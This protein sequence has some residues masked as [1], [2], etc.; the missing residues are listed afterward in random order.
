[1]DAARRTRWRGMLASFGLGMAATLAAGPIAWAQSTATAAAPGSV[2]ATNRNNQTASAG[3]YTAYPTLN[4][5][6]VAPLVMLVM[7]RDEQ[8][9]IKAY[10]DYT[11]L[12]GDG[13]IDSTYNNNFSYS[14]YFDPDLC[15]AYGSSTFKA[16]G[17]ASKH[18]CVSAQ[19]GKWSG[20]FLNWVAMSRLDVVRYVLYGGYRSTDDSSTVLERAGIPND[21]HAWAKVYTGSDVD[22]YTPFSQ[23]SSNNGISF[24]NAT[25]S[26][27]GVPQMRV[28]R[29][30]WSEWASTAARQCDWKETIGSANED[31]SY[32]DDASKS[33]DGLG[34]KEYTVRVQVC[35]AG[36]SVREA[37]CQRYGTSYKPVGLLQRY[38]EN[39]QMRFGLLTGSFSAPRSG[40]VLRRNIGKLAGNGTADAN[41]NFAGCATGDEVDLS[42]GQFCGQ[43]SG[44][45][46]IINTLNRI[47]L[48]QWNYT[49]KWS[50]CDDYGILNR[51]TSSSA[52]SGQKRLKNPGSSGSGSQNCSAWGNPLSEMYAEALR[53][54]A[55]DGAKT[56]DFNISGDLSGLPSVDW[57]DPY[58]V[59]S[60][61]GSVRNPYCAG[62]SI[63]VLSTGLN[64]F[65][66]DEIPA[67]SALG[68]DAAS[69]ATKEVGVAEGIS[70]NYLVGRVGLTPKNTAINTYE[71]LC[72]ANAVTDLS[73]VR[74]ICPDIPSMEGSYLIAGLAYR[75][76]TNDLRPNLK[77]PGG[78]DRPKVCDAN[79][80]NCVSYKN[81]VQTYAVALAENL[82]KFQIP[83]GTGS[84]TLAPLCQANNSGSA[85]ASSSGWRSCYLG[86]VGIGQK[87]SAI[88]PNNYIYGRAM[89]SNAS[90]G[91]FSLVWEDSLWGNDHDNDVVA[92]LTYCVGSR[93]SDNQQTGRKKTNGSA[94][95]GY[96]ICWRS[97]S[98][99]CGSDGKPSVGT[100]EV[101]VRI[102]VLSA[103]AG[104]AMLSGYTV[105]GSNDDGVKRVV[106]R[107][108][109]KNGSV[110]TKSVDP[111]A[112]WNLPKVAKYSLGSGGARQLENPLYYA[113]KYGGFSDVA[114][115][116]GTIATAP[117]D[118]PK[119]AVSNWDRVDNNTGQ[120]RA[121]GGGD[122][123]PDNFFPV[124][125]PALLG[126]RLADVFNKILARSGSGTS[127][128][129]V[130]T[131]AGGDGLTYQ[132]LYQA[133]QQN[134]SGSQKV[135]WTGSL[136]AMWTDPAG[137]MRAG[138]YNVNGVPTLGTEK[139]SPIVLFC[140]NA[141]GESRFMTY[142]DASTVPGS[143]PA[144]QCTGSTLDQ[145]QPVW[146]AQSLL[147]AGGYQTQ[148]Q[149]SYNA[150][151]TASSGR[152][153]FTWV[154]ENH[155]GQVDDG[156]QKD[157]AWASGALSGTGTCTGSAF[158]GN[159]R[160]LNT[161]SADGAASLVSWVRGTELVDASGK[162]DAN[163]R[164]RTLDGSVYRL[165]DIINSTPLAV[166]TPAEAFDLLYADGSYSG[167]R[168][169]YQNRR[170]MVYVGANDGM[171]H[172]F[173]GG[174][175]DA[176]AHQLNTQPKTCSKD[177]GCKA[178]TG[179]T[180]HPLGAEVWAYVPG[181]LL[182][183]LRWLA[184]PTY[185]HMFYVDGSAISQDVRIFKADKDCAA[186]GRTQCHPD[187]W[188][189]V[190]IVPFRFGGGPIGLDT[191][192]SSNGVTVQNSFPA[193]VVLD[194]TNPEAPPSVLAELTNL[195]EVGAGCSGKLVSCSDLTRVISTYTSS[196]PA[197][198]MFRP[199]ATSNPDPSKFYLFTGSGTTD[200]GGVGTVEGGT[201]SSSAG[202]AIRGFDM[203]NLASRDATPVTWGNGT[204][205][206]SL[207]NTGGTGNGGQSFAG[208]LIASDFNLDGIAESLY[209]GSVKGSS[210]TFSGGLWA[211]DFG[212]STDPSAWLP[213]QVLSGLG[214]PVTIRPTLGL[215]DRQ[216]RMV[217][218]GTGRAYTKADMSSQQQQVI[219]AVIDGG[220]TAAF[221]GLQDVTNIDITVD[222]K[223][224]NAGTDVTD[225]SA[226]QALAAKA[227]GW[228]YNL[229]TTDASGKAIPSERVV[230][231]QA[232]SDRVLLTSTYLPGT[233]TCTDQGEGFL[234]GMDYKS[235][236]PNPGLAGFL[237]SHS[238]TK[239][240][241]INRSV[242]L[243]AGLPSQPSL[244]RSVSNG[245]SQ[246]RVCV[247]TSTGAI[248]CYDVPTMNGVNSGEISWREP[249]D[250]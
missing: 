102:E 179:F 83:V 77:T 22:K 94:Y 151:A 45:E 180:A 4:A 154:D 173:N 168:R 193:Y 232:L 23:S 145:L 13:L 21:L 49:S 186:G 172:A 221:S 223:V 108:G 227:G 214:K 84:I 103:Y 70:G 29:G 200:N 111:D 245:S 150:A 69:K 248:I 28:A 66:S 105:T 249:L 211:I 217:F 183:H 43:A 27:G 53:Y 125:N 137:H 148:T 163:W 141:Q 165:G 224:L 95:T 73:L 46:G 99:I 93:C 80:A 86:A 237:G 166:G 242:S 220:G 3:N 216:Q 117:C 88:S 207:T 74:G 133:Q 16:S 229:S 194:V 52:G 184:D 50:D 39:G 90:A 146:S 243:G 238:T 156:E 210:T 81:K 206:E 119:C 236:S 114:Q 14:G 135:S 191:K 212:G 187:G 79:G 234:Y 118:P 131:S 143:I 170:Q 19:A 51:E 178:D 63:I 136:N 25:V 106:L 196:L 41:G 199:R 57:K 17:A 32:R 34:D 138:G 31:N 54:V 8:L 62:C 20:N 155:N 82:P 128:A 152:Y 92:M 24:C 182:P 167:F 203:A 169:V 160:F 162:A 134:K 158:T 201:A 30:N 98:T 132:A 59:D 192:L 127:A 107:P 218:F 240:M 228:Y 176:S 189:T 15:Y 239:G 164:S 58:G 1:M 47:A 72:T 110:L 122:G 42:T 78:L 64:S 36:S 71:D 149:R 35:D 198:A 153:I 100:N 161:C 195:T 159:F 109:D 87:T 9:F 230:S 204:T 247:Q 181:N 101:L 10:T 124:R 144:A 219:A 202:L 231:T 174:F 116:D 89:E 185:A 225:T 190:L 2:I 67:I 208:D 233:D 226:L 241:I 157:F 33:N 55:N 75:A 104:N 209:F 38:G 65:D 244:K 129:V 246:L 142:T 40:G 213:R 37:F 121:V 205:V 130:S 85:T 250:N 91:S 177:G 48:T 175:Y 147:S 171:L 68:T 215:N 115:S 44:T 26:S 126:E 188:G 18:Q 139:Q 76:W 56:S 60:A 123:L 197:V 222:G 120:P 5:S 97:D 61:T 96:D 7:S 112:N 140:T 113:A 12:D 235:G 6:A 11:D